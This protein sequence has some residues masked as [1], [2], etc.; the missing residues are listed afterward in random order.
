MIVVGKPEASTTDNGNN[1]FQKTDAYYR[2]Q[3][4]YDNFKN[5]ASCGGSCNS[6]T[7]VVIYGQ[8]WTIARI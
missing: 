7:E 4:Q 8:Q 1:N 3:N 2:Q 6:R 5:G